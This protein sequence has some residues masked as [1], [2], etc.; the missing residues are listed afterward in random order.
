MVATRHPIQRDALGRI[1]T[2]LALFCACWLAP[3]VVSRAGDWPFPQHD[4]GGTARALTMGAIS[5][6]PA[7][8]PTLIGSVTIGTTGVTSLLFTPVNGDEMPDIVAVTRSRVTAFD[9]ID[10]TRIWQTP[11][12]LATMLVGLFDLDG[13]GQQQELVVTSSVPGGGIHAVDV[14]TGGVL[15]SM[16]GLDD[17][18]SVRDLEVQVVNLDDTPA[19]EL[20]FADH[21]GGDDDLYLVD[22]SGGMSSPQVVNAQLPV[23]WR[24][25]NPMVAGDLL[26]LDQP[27]AIYVRQGAHRTAFERCAATDPDAWCDDGEV[28]CLC[29]LGQFLSL[30]TPWSVGPLWKKD[31]N[32]DGREEIVDIANYVRDATGLYVLDLSQGF[33]SG[34]PVVQDLVLWG[35]NYGL[36]SPPTALLVPDDNLADLDGDGDPDLLLTFYNNAARELD[37]LGNPADDGIERPDAFTLALFD[38]FTGLLHFSLPDAIAWGAV[39]LDGNGIPEIVV[40]PTDGW[41]YLPGLAGI[42]LE[43]TT[44]CQFRQKWSIDGRTALRDLENLG[45]VS[46]PTPKLHPVRLDG[47]D[48]LVAFHGDTLEAIRYLSDGAVEVVA[49][50]DLEPRE[51]LFASSPDGLY[52][53]LRSPE[54]VRLVTSDLQPVSGLFGLPG[55]QVAEVLAVQFEPDDPTASLIVNG[56][57]YH[58]IGVPQEGVEPA[59]Q[60]LPHVAFGDD[61]DQDGYPELFAYSRIKESSTGHLEIEVV[62]YQGD[63]SAEVSSPFSRR[64]SWSTSAEPDLVGFDIVSLDGNAIRPIQRDDDPSLEI[65]VPLG[66]AT[67][68]QSRIL[69]FDG[70]T[71][72]LEEI[73]DP[74]WIVNQRSFGFFADYL[75]V[76]IE[77]LVDP[78]GAGSPDGLEDIVYVNNLRLVMW[79]G[80]ADEP[81]LIHYPKMAPYEGA[82]GDLNGDGALDLLL[83]LNLTT[84]PTYTA[85][86]VAADFADLWGGPFQ[87]FSPGSHNYE[88][89]ALIDMDESP[90]LDFVHGSGNGSIDIYSGAS[91]QILDGFPLYLD[92]GLLSDTFDPQAVTLFSTAVFDCDGDGYEEVLAGSADGFLYALNVDP[93][94]EGA[95]SLEWRVAVGYPVSRIRIA[96]IDGDGLDE[97]IIASQDSTVRIYDGLGAELTILQPADGECL[98]TTPFSVFGTARNLSTVDLSIGGGTSVGPIPIL[99]GNWTAELEPPGIGTWL[100]EAIGRDG[101]GQQRARDQLLVYFGGDL[102]G[103]GFTVCGGDCDDLNETAYPGAPEILDGVDNNCDGF[104]DEGLD[105][106]PED[107]PDEPEE[108]EPT[109]EEEPDAGDLPADVE[110]SDGPDMASDVDPPDAADS[111]LDTDEEDIRDISD[112][113]ESD[114]PEMSIDA[115]PPE[116]ADDSGQSD[117]RDDIESPEETDQVGQEDE[118]DQEP[119][120]FP[121]VQ[122]RD[123]RD[124]SD[125]TGLPSSPSDRGCGCNTPAGNTPSSLAFLLGVGVLLFRRRKG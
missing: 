21:Y 88:S 121:S 6:D 2:A 41:T 13:D 83:M 100:I 48:G 50:L 101:Q 68:W 125:D 119:P 102:D 52:L 118:P 59:F 123:T 23:G 56:A 73:I 77:D 72:E 99:L 108:M 39:D 107:P 9:G 110:M 19:Q 62:G 58:G 32:G 85:V 79:P 104:T 12:L 90:G 8:S 11:P 70:L 71:G 114:G 17:R 115:D 66:N 103:D 30:H 20:I 78:S 35:Y 44:T 91:G 31:L 24:S 5:A 16:T 28:L 46:F 60:A 120:D 87:L 111:T 47:Q 109:I 98:A 65:L 80:G 27:W 4:Q 92:G 74:A 124:D 3:P 10:G 36:H 89:L 42:E 53:L 18:A 81:S 14:R 57:I 1:A 112:A 94:E 75:P 7:Q 43:C 22:F 40:S 97:V 67:T 55:Q 33:S 106:D 38:A 37:A 93:R 63:D 113:E 54:T 45:G 25:Y 122:P 51:V 61:L 117:L 82:F 29:L 34:D 49:S 95:P 105:P 64:W 116:E 26:G 15:W 86:D 96:D 76:W 84:N 69:F